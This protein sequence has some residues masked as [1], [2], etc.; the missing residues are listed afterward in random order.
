MI[1][2]GKRGPDGPVVTVDDV[3]LDP[4]HDLASKTSGPS[5]DQFEWGY[6]GA[7][8]TCLALAILAHNFN[9]DARA[10]TEHRRFLGGYIAGIRQDE[11]ALDGREIENI[12]QGFVSVPMTLDELLD[13][14]RQG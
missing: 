6:D 2:R 7:G 1:F 4:R 13:K 5:A 9:D 11:W 12:L 3:A 10:L 14:V 8:P